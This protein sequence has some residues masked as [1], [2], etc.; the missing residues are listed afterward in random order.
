M[1]NIGCTSPSN[2][3]A[4]LWTADA[5]ND[6]PQQRMQAGQRVILPDYSSSGDGRRRSEEDAKYSSNDDEEEAKQFTQ[7]DEDTRATYIRVLKNKRAR[8]YPLLRFANVVEFMS[9]EM[10]YC[11][12]SEST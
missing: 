7:L 2:D 1:G 3:T 8:G 5:G 11:Q 10:P 4:S 12:D 6:G 9:Q